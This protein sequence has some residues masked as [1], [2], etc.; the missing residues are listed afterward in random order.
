MVLLQMKLIL[1]LKLK[2]ILRLLSV[3]ASVALQSSQLVRAA[4]QDLNKEVAD[5]TG[6]RRRF[7]PLDD[8]V[9]CMALDDTPPSLRA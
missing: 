7:A 8:G 3:A 5:W 6:S 9:M 1:K 4:Q 2:E